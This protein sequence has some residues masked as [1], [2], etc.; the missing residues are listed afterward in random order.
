MGEVKSGTSFPILRP[1]S[2]SSVSGNMRKLCSLPTESES[3]S[4]WRSSMEEMGLFLTSSTRAAGR[5]SPWNT[6][7]H[8]HTHHISSYK[9]LNEQHTLSRTIFEQCKKRKKEGV[10]YVSILSEFSQQF[11]GG[12]GLTP[13]RFSSQRVF[14]VW[15][16]KLRPN[17]VH[18][19]KNSKPLWA[20]EGFVYKRGLPLQWLTGEKHKKIIT[21]IY[22]YA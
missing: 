1:R 13:Q 8:T 17:V 7:T 14:C 10:S 20:S 19:V 21:C 6:H 2:E 15:W 3:S 5:A 11:T 9:R 4:S 22:I 12:D 18:S 16:L